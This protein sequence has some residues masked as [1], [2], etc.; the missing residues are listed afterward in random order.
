[1]KRHVYRERDYAFAQLVLTLRTAIGL[2][3]VGLAERL[4]ASRRAVVDWEGGLSYPKAERLKQLIILGM[5]QHAFAAGREEEEIR[6]LWKAAHQKVLL[7]EDWLHDL[8]APL[9]PVPLSPPAGTLAAP[10]FAESASF[11][12]V[13]L[14]EALDVSH[15]AGREVEVAELSQWILEERCRLVTLLGMGGIGK[16]MLA[17]YLGSRLAPHFE[18]VLWRSLRDAPNVRRWSPT[19]SPSSPRRRPRTSPPR[20]SSASRGL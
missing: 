16:S 10:A 15:F 6:A 5:Q 8:L 2:S 18:A 1:V 9:A 3:Q 11:P 7:D 13:N 19:A 14:V 12:R 17:S 20:W 4:G